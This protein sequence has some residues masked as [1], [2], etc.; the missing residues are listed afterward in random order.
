MEVLSSGE[1]SK[2]LFISTTPTLG[3]ALTCWL[4]S[5]QAY[6]KSVDTTEI[7]GDLAFIR[8][9]RVALSSPAYL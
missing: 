6:I 2:S 9:H 3:S 8:D 1:S 4:Q 5:R 7:E